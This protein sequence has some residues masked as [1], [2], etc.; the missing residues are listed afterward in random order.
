MQTGKLTLRQWLALFF[1]YS[2]ANPLAPIIDPSLKIS[3]LVGILVVLLFQVGIRFL[4]ADLLGMTATVTAKFLVS[5]GYSCFVSF[6]IFGC[7]LAFLYKHLKTSWNRNCL[8]DGTA[9][10]IPLSFEEWHW[11]LIV[12]PL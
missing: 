12:P 6:A 9:R 2:R 5:F 10:L 3:L 1:Q 11:G 4:K 7:M 8:A